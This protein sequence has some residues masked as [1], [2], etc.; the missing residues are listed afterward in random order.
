MAARDRHP[1]LQGAI[2]NPAEGVRGSRGFRRDDADLNITDP[3]YRDH[4]QEIDRGARDPA[5]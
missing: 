1:R 2:L 4:R 3:T 5:L